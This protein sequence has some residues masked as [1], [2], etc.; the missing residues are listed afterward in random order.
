MSIQLKFKLCL[1]GNKPS[2]RG[3]NCLNA[4]IVAHG[5]KFYPKLTYACRSSSKSRPF[6]TLS[7]LLIDYKEEKMQTSIVFWCFYFSHHIFIPIT[8]PKI[9]PTENIQ[10]SDA[11]SW[12][13]KLRI[14]G[15]L[16]WELLNSM[17]QWEYS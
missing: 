13:W 17:C 2:M 10:L 9:N 5:K 12:I 4:K 11:K 14:K 7:T 1:I 6:V 16:L 8:T 3:L 15:Y